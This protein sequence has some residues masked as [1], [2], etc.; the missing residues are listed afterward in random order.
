MFVVLL[1][2]YNV[3][4]ILWDP[5]QFLR[6]KTNQNFVYS[7]SRSHTMQ[8]IKSSKPKTN[9]SG[10]VYVLHNFECF[11]ILTLQG[12][13]RNLRKYVRT[14]AIFSRLMLYLLHSLPPRIYRI[15]W[16]CLWSPYHLYVAR[17]TMYCQKLV[18]K[19]CRVIRIKLNQMVW[20]NVRII[21]ILLRQW[22]HNNTRFTRY[23][24]LSN[25]LNNRLNVCLH[26]AGGCSTG[27]STGLTTGCIV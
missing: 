1:L 9:L 18:V 26:D 10:N 17:Q 22:Y 15:K 23:N 11:T 6:S 20:E 12:A 3:G 8:C 5:P 14:R 2:L 19:I 7:I 13:E 4:L 21:I 24:R 16:R 27:W 25:R